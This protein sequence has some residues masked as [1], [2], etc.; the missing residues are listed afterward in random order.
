MGKFR[1]I[2]AGWLA[3]FASVAPGAMA[4]ESRGVVIS[5]RVDK[6]ELAGTLVVPADGKPKAGIIMASGSGAQD[7][8]ES[9]LGH[10]PFKVIAET[11]ADKGY[12]G[13][14][15]KSFGN[16]IYKSKSGNHAFRGDESFVSAC[17]YRFTC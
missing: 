10:K 4:F 9:L 3:A 16:Q 1:L 13:D 17:S 2:C 11:L 6:V 5:N 15:G 7:R 14:S 8:D 12:A